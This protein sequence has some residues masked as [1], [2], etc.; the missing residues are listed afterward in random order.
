MSGT[1]NTW[2]LPAE[3]RDLTTN[4]A[5]SR[6]KKSQLTILPETFTLGYKGTPPYWDI[7][8][9]LLETSE[10]YPRAMASYGVQ[11][12]SCIFNIICGPYCPLQRRRIKL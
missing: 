1:N 12:E 7:A 11:E 6:S 8:A 10:R 4:F 2:P 5:S 9:V 3:F